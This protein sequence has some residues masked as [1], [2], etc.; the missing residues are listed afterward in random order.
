MLSLLHTQ[1]FAMGKQANAH[2][3]SHD[4]CGTPPIQRKEGR[5][6]SWHSPPIIC[7]QLRQEH[8]QDSK[9]PQKSRYEFFVAM[10]TE[11]KPPL[12]ALLCIT[13]KKHSSSAR[14]IFLV[15]FWLFCHACTYWPKT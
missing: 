13:M 15:A 5:D 3:V 8:S 12:E 4:P 10:A 2:G 1:H 11:S 14:I 6:I 9:I 7:H